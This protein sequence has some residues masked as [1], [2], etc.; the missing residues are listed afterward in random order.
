MNKF[1]AN[2]LSLLLISFSFSL[3]QDISKSEKDFFLY[4]IGNSHTWDFR[5]SSDFLQIAKTLHVDISNGWHINCGQNLKTIWN[6]P[7]QTCVDLT[8]YGAYKDA[9]EN[10][11]WDAITIQT[12]IGGTGKAEK[13]AVEEFLSFIS[14]SINKDCDV[15]IY[16]TWPQNTA[17]QL[18]DFNYS[19][20]W[21][22]DFQEN[23]TLKILSEKYFSYLEN[24][25][26]E[27]P[28]R[29]KFIPVGKVLY[30]F[31]KKAKSGKFPGFSGS[32]ELYRDAWHL[33]NVGRYI[34]GLTVFSQIFRIDPVGIP[35]FESYYTSD[36]WPGDRELTSKQKELIR[37]IISEAL[38]F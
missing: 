13:K 2:V 25:I 10:H 8:E 18:G 5:P 29:I 26:E 27:Y 36:K 31:D 23:D 9:I 33:N 30:H 17:V 32:G 4:S 19:E 3:A 11:K 35:D 21:L 16:F 24:S 28:D 22:A 6:N 15:F 7:E 38:N 34:A 20:V 1:A 37:R 14:Q 12:F